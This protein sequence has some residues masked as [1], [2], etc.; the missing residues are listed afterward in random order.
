MKIKIFVDL[1]Y[2]K[3]ERDVNFW[4]EENVGEFDVVD[5][6]MS[7]CS[8]GT[9]GNTQYTLMVMYCSHQPAHS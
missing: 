7:N 2:K 8:D 3:L 9:F 6:R 1:D 5:V 4:I